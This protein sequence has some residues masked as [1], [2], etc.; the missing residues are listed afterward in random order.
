MS[1]TA[2][3][4]SGIVDPSLLAGSVVTAPELKIRFNTFEEAQ[5]TEKKFSDS[6]VDGCLQDNLT[7]GSE[8][9]GIKGYLDKVES[10]DR[11]D[12][13]IAD[14]EAIAGLYLS[15]TEMITRNLK[16]AVAKNPDEAKYQDRR[17]AIKDAKDRFMQK[18]E[19]EAGGV[20]D[21][22][23]EWSEGRSRMFPVSA[24]E[25][26]GLEIDGRDPLNAEGKQA[27]DFRP[28]IKVQRQMAGT[29]V[30]A[31]SDTRVREK[32]SKQDQELG[33]RIYLNPDV[34]AVPEIFEQ[35]LQ[36]ANEAGL[37]IQLKMFQRASEF[38][39]AHL[40]RRKGKSMDGLRGDGIVIYVSDA[41][42]N[43]VL[44]MVLTI[45]KDKSEAFIGRKTS[46][47][48][49]M[50]AEGIAIGDE[51]TQ[52]SGTSLTSHR[53]KIFS[54]AANYV[55]QKGKNGEEARELFRRCVAATAQANKVNPNN[56]AF[57]LQ[58]Q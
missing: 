6:F 41:Q 18:L 38:A 36:A 46:R 15:T 20:A 50:V 57:N 12:A 34:V 4:Q 16:I 21:E 10:T 25:Y 44:S 8:Q 31:Y 32:M 3:T 45:A 30:M 43:E 17:A 2:P 39:Q 5:N 19:D 35:V 29:F 40:V 47:I 48:P 11:D 9:V 13:I 37:S 28:N 1:E 14:P 54:Y 51:P 22:I 26:S 24:V 55:K 7:V 58:T 49:Q 23:V 42:A 53:E 33:K 56:V 27:E 52:M